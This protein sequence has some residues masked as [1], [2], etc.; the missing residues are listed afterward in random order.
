MDESTKDKVASNLTDN[1]QKKV[2][3]VYEFM[4]FG[5]ERC[6]AKII[7]YIHPLGRQAC[8]T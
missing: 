7:V 8:C 1:L 5:T 4:F 2:N 6:M 3:K